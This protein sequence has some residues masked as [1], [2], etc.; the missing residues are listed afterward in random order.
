MKILVRL[1]FISTLLSAVVTQTTRAQPLN[2]SAAMTQG[3][4]ID[5]KSCTHTN[6]CLDCGSVP[7]GLVSGTPNEFFHK[8][9]DDKQ[10]RKLKGTLLIQVMIDST[11]HACCPR[12]QNF[13]Y[14]F[15]SSIEQ[16]KIAAL[17]SSTSWQFVQQGIIRRAKWRQIVSC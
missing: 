8:N 10:A 5:Y 6:F 15:N 13:T 4:I 9:I 3:K 16:L 12:I 11:G 2:R 1:L 14:A 7:A 17:V